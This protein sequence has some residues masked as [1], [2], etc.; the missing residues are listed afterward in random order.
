[1]KDEEDIDYVKSIITPAMSQIESIPGVVA[2]GITHSRY[3]GTGKGFQLLVSVETSDVKKLIPE[4]INGIHVETVVIGKV[5]AL[6]E[7]SGV[8]ERI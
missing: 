8:I 6:V 2:V 5:R 4:S 1:M 7:F 3:T